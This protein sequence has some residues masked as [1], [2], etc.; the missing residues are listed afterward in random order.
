[1][2]SDQYIALFSHFIACGAHESWYLLDGIMN[3]DMDIQPETIH[4]DTHQQSFAVFGL[5]HLLGIELMPRIRSVKTLTFFKPTPQ[6]KYKNINPLFKDHIR[7]ELISKAYPDMLRLVMSVQ[8]GLLVPSV[9]LRRL[10]TSNDILALGLMELGKVVRTRFLLQVISDMELRRIQHRETNKTEQWH[11]F[12]DMITFGNNGTVRSNNP[13]DQE[14]MIQYRHLVSDL[15]ILYNTH[16]MT[17]SINALR[18][19]GYPIVDED[20]AHISPYNLYGL[21]LIGDYRVD[22]KR[23]LEPMEE[24]LYG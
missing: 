16:H 24:L 13:I 19:E 17:K 3:N 4:G 8:Q 14:K 7:W 10:N 9:I 20:L 21:R 22:V 15:V 23:E 5:A 11:H 12:L 6:A 18:D 1:M 2:I